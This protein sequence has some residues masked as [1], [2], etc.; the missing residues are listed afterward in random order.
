MWNVVSRWKKLLTV[1]W[2]QRKG[3][4]SGNEIK[5]CDIRDR[6]LCSTEWECFST[7]QE[8]VSVCQ[9]LTVCVLHGFCVTHTAWVHQDSTPPPFFFSSFFFKEL[10]EF[11]WDC[12]QSK[13]RWTVDP[14]TTTTTHP[15]F[16][17][18]FLGGEG[19]VLELSSWLV[20]ELLLKWR[21]EEN[22]LF[23]GWGGGG[24]ASL[25]CL[26]VSSHFQVRGSSHVCLLLLACM[27]LSLVP[28]FQLKCKG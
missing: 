18:F 6:H 22:E 2:Q 16:V 7:I 28:E 27:C 19:G 5:W 17:T 15:H 11:Y 24:G 23:W 13:S 14:L 1:V 25:D 3:K 12:P 26:S 21:F 8:L 4:R 9:L 20:K 10:G